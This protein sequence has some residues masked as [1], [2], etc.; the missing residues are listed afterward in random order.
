MRWLDVIRSIV[1]IESKTIGVGLPSTE[2]SAFFF[3]ELRP[4]IGDEKPHPGSIF[5]S[6]FN[7]LPR[8]HKI[9]YGLS[10]LKV[11]D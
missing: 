4:I 2:V 5:L 3:G 8:A 11:N 6:G 9:M 1:S 7:R 10:G